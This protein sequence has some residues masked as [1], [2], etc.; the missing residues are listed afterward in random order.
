MSTE[1]SYAL[2]QWWPLTRIRVDPAKYETWVDF[3]RAVME[4]EGRGLVGEVW[5]MQALWVW[6]QHRKR[7]GLPTDLY[8]LIP[9]AQKWTDSEIQNGDW[10]C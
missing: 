10:P 2:A 9:R 4:I 6:N 1:R 5:E 7:V 8:H 3:H